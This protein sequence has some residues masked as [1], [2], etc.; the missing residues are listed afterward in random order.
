M[1]VIG[2]QLE[3]LDHITP[4]SDR[5]FLA[6]LVQKLGASC[7]VEVGC[8]VG[9]T[10]R[11]LVDASSTVIVHA[12]DHF[13]GNPNDRLGDLSQKHGKETIHRTFCENLSDCL[14][15]RVFLHVGSSELYARI[16]PFQADLIFIDAC[17]D[18]ESV[19][20]DIRAWSPHVR[21]GGVLCGH[22]YGVFEGVTRAAN[23]INPDTVQ[24]LVWAKR[25]DA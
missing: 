21:Q 22:D 3:T 7:V 20:R 13:E 1:L 8:Y 18:Y 19:K 11:S 5:L 12:I 2:K 23:E 4:K 14:F 17:H 24:G 9:L 15:K 6:S 10:T 25:I 16:W